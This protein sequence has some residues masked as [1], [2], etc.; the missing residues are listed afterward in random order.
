MQILIKAV[1]F[2]NACI[3]VAG[4]KLKISFSTSRPARC[5]VDLCSNHCPVHQQMHNDHGE[6]MGAFTY[7]VGALKAADENSLLHLEWLKIEI[8]ENCTKGKVED[9]C[10]HQLFS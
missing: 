10:L 6:I 7:N 3:H 2:Y 5:H 8:G 1:R 9:T 4:R